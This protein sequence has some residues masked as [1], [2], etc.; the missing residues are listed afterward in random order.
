MFCLL[1]C[2]CFQR[3]VQVPFFA[4][5][6][7]ESFKSLCL[8][9]QLTLSLWAFQVA[10]VVKNTAANAGDIRDALDPPEEG[11]ATHFSIPFK[12]LIYLF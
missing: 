9:V 5:S 7:T 10:L 11:M 2:V 8:D 12:K 3:R 1:A 4:L 6:C